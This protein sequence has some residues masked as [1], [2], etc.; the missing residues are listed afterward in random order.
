MRINKSVS[1]H[2]TLKFSLNGDIKTHN[3]FLSVAATKGLSGYPVRLSLLLFLR[4]FGNRLVLISWRFWTTSRSRLELISFCVLPTRLCQPQ[5]VNIYRI[6]AI[7]V[8]CCCQN[9]GKWKKNFGCVS[10]TLIMYKWNFEFFFMMLI[11]MKLLT[12]N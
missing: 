4:F 8:I 11:S 7:C 12:E 10:I 9:K 5:R 2:V 3:S 1:E 6:C